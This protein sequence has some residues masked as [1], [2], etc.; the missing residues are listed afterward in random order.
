[1]GAP[2]MRDLLARYQSLSLDG[3]LPAY[4][5][6]GPEGLPQFASNLAVVEPTSDGEIAGER[7]L[8]RASA[9]V[10]FSVIALDID[11]FK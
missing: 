8:T 9:P 7:G 6:F 3:S 2:Q 10:P 4:A 5:D 11:H 1:V